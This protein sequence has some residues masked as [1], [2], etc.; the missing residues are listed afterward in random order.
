ME[1]Q[2]NYLQEFEQEVRLIP[3]D[4][5]L[6]FVNLLIDTLVFY[7]IA[8]VYGFI[9]VAIVLS[10]GTD[11]EESFLVQETGAPVF[12]QYL[13]SVLLYLAYY[14][15]F[16][17]ASKGRTLGKL[18]TGTVAMRDDGNT[19]GWKDAILRSLCRLIPLEAFVALFTPPWHDS[20]TRTLVVKKIK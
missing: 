18:V 6:R 8:F 4:K 7:A 5:G 17:A 2:P 9:H 1:Q 16:E 11:P 15:I 20:I 13:I 12:F 19:I 14:T 10:Q 3:A